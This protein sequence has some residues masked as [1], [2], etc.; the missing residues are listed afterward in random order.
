VKKKYPKLWDWYWNHISHSSMG[1]EEYEQGFKEF[2]Q[3]VE[4]ELKVKK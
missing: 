3:I 4:E 1:Q 2:I